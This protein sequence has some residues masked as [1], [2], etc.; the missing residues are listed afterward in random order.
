MSWRCA[1]EEWGGVGAGAAE[2]NG[3][4]GSLLLTGQSRRRLIACQLYAVNKHRLT[5]GP[6]QDLKIHDIIGYFLI[7]VYYNLKIGYVSE[8]DLTSATGHR[9]TEQRLLRATYVHSDT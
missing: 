4:G 1:R 2:M 9:P 7:T 3:A 8:W 5:S 6:A